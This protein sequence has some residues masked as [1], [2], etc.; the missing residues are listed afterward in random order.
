VKSTADRWARCA[1]ALK[2]E[3]QKH[4]DELITMAKMHSC[5]SFIAGEDTLEAVVFSV[6]VEMIKRQENQAHGDR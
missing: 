3:D 2:R 1:R 5:D 6:L 4:G